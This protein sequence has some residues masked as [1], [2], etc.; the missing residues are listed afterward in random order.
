M[1]D[2][3]DRAMQVL[4]EAWHG[5]PFR[6]SSPA[7]ALALGVSHA[8]TRAALGRLMDRR[9]ISIWSQNGHPFVRLHNPPAEIRPTRLGGSFRPKPAKP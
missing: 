5:R 1:S 3:E 4:R 6:C 8:E 2:L 7:L 9:E